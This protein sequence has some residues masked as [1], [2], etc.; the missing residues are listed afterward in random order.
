[1]SDEVSPSTRK[2]L[3]SSFDTAKYELLDSN[4]DGVKRYM[5]SGTVDEELTVYYPFSNGDAWALGTGA[6]TVVMQDTE[7]RS[8]DQFYGRL[9]EAGVDFLWDE[10]G[11]RALFDVD[12][13]ESQSV[14]LY[15]GERAGDAT[16]YVPPEVEEGYDILL[17]RP[18]LSIDEEVREEALKRA[19]EY[20]EEDGL[21]VHGNE[22][23]IKKLLE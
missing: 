5:E 18:G 14:V 19:L 21:V 9:K 15:A 4:C 16:A 17:W 23:E 6:G 20:L 12:V 7:P 10:Y 11:G 3:V 22:P 1:M 2:N 13:G 8:V